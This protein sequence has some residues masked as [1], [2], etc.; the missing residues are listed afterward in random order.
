MLFSPL[1]GQMSFEKMPSHQMLQR[2][3]EVL[4]M[5]DD[6]STFQTIEVE[7]S[8]HW[9]NAQIHWK[10][11]SYCPTFNFSLDWLLLWHKLYFKCIFWWCLNILSISHFI[12]QSFHQPI[13]SLM[14]LFISQS[15]H[16]PI[17]SLMSFFINQ[18]FHQLAVLST[19]FID[20]LVV[21]QTWYI[22]NKSFHQSLFYPSVISSTSYFFNQ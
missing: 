13:V 16:Q 7:Y 18:L 8:L 5:S 12:N 6:I 2:H 19:C 1:L 17:V 3:A 15:F 14:S 21:S 22:F 10:K 20:Q 9:S 4:C 11:I